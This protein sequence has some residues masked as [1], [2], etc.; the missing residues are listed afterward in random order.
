VRVARNDNSYAGS[1][2][3]EFE[4]VHIVD[5]IELYAAEFE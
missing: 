1:S 3:V 2:R 4:L 5:D